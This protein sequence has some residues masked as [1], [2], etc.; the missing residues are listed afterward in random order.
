MFKELVLQDKVSI[1]TGGSGGIGH[2]ITLILAEMGSQVFFTY[3]TNKEKAIALQ[4]EAQTKGLKVFAIAL[5][6]REQAACQDMVQTIYEQTQRIDI[7]VNNSGTTRDNLLLGLEEEDIRSVIDTNLL[8]VFYMTQAIV[9]LMM[10]ARSGKIINL[11]SIAGEKGGVV[12][13]IMRQAKV[14]SMLSPKQW[15]WNLLPKKLQLTPL[16]QGL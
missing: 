4:D 11:S 13:V 10:R 5:D 14:E 8:G 15:L 1:V 3:H 6:V 9:P 7:L 12:K 2:A 16:R